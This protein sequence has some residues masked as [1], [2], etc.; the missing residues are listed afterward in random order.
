M[1]SAPAGAQCI[2]PRSCVSSLKHK[3]ELTPLPEEAD[4]LFDRPLSPT[5]RPRLISPQVTRTTAIRPPPL[6]VE[7]PLS[8]SRT[9]L[10]E[11]A[12]MEEKM[13]RGSGEWNNIAVSSP[14]AALAGLDW[15][16]GMFLILRPHPRGIL[17]DAGANPFCTS[18]ALQ[19]RCWPNGGPAVRHP[20]VETLFTPNSNA[21]I[22]SYH[23]P[24]TSTRSGFAITVSHAVSV[25]ATENPNPTAT[26]T[27]QGSSKI[28]S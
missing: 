27:A 26:K 3:M 20:W 8:R 25:C 11:M 14:P 4:D 21:A 2:Y 24:H 5:P 16:G 7:T 1:F 28:G 6:E 13:L 9:P 10:N 15:L 17:Y 19:G 23:N 12:A 18:T 22:R